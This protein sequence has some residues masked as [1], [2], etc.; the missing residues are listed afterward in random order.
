MIVESSWGVKMIKIFEHEKGWQQAL[1]LDG[2]ILQM[3]DH[4]VKSLTHSRDLIMGELNK[5]SNG[6]LF[7][8][9]SPILKLSHFSAP[10]PA[11]AE[12]LLRWVNY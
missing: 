12:E 6:A 10:P 8:A 7:C 3:Y 5:T 11:C 1:L 2:L 9:H 4:F